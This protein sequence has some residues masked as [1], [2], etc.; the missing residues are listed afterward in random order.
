VQLEVWKRL[1]PADPRYQ[2]WK[3]V[4][5]TR[6]WSVHGRA[7][8]EARGDGGVRLPADG[9]SVVDMYGDGYPDN[10]G[11]MLSR[12]ANFAGSSPVGDL[13]ICGE[14][15]ALPGCKQ[16]VVELREG[17]RRYQFVI[18]GPA[19]AADARARIEAALGASPGPASSTAAGPEPWKL[20]AGKSVSFAAQNMDDML[21]L[22]LDG[23][24]VATLEIPRADDQSSSYTLRVEGE[25]ADFDGVEVFRDIFYYPGSG[26]GEFEIPPGNYVMLGDNT[27]DSSDSREWNLAT[28]HWDGDGSNGKVVRGNSYVGQNPI[29][30]SGLPDGTHVFFRD[31]WGE[32][33][34]FVEKPGNQGPLLRA[35]YVPRNL[36]TG[37][38]VIVF[39]PLTW[40]WPPNWGDDKVPIVT[41]LQW[42]H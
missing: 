22:E 25:G 38:A 5:G 17:A 8:I 11:T 33:H 40:L 28:F 36:I 32:L 15:K 14:I 3:P 20:R 42:V 21:Q 12:A 41:R 35:S 29:R 19:A 26:G 16:V 31:E 39:W 7:R 9:G 10:M 37:R 24:I 18:P 30:R 23:D 6:T 34:D 4:E 2:A 27:Q 1:N 13:R